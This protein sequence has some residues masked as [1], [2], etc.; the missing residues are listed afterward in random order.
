MNESS[1]PKQIDITCLEPLLT[2]IHNLV[3]EVAETD[4]TLAEKLA[5]AFNTLYLTMWR[6]MRG[7]N[8]VLNPNN[9]KYVEQKSI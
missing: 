5:N 2:N 8:G 6:E 4:P 7:T 1:Y 9:T 3:R